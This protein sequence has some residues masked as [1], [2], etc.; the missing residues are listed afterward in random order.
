MRIRGSSPAPTTVWDGVRGGLLYN[1]NSY[2]SFR[3][4]GGVV[5]WAEFDFLALLFNVHGGGLGGVGFRS[6]IQGCCIGG[7]KITPGEGGGI[8]FPE[9]LGLEEIEST[10]EKFLLVGVLGI[11]D[12]SESLLLKIYEVKSGLNKPENPYD[13]TVFINLNFMIHFS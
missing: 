9:L 5:G 2:L 3:L 4:A 8:E 1:I 11:P 10:F 6:N 12:E 7:D 13:C